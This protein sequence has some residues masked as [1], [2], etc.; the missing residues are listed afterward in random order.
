MSQ[1]SSS[2]HYPAEVFD[3]SGR[4]YEAR[5]AVDAVQTALDRRDNGGPPAK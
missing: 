2:E 1:A 3:G 4:S 5:D